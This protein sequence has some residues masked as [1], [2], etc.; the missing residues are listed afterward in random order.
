MVAGADGAVGLL[1]QNHVEE[2]SVIR[3]GFAITQLRRTTARSV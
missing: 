2:G 3:N 1:A